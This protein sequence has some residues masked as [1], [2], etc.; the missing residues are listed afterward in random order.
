MFSVNVFYSNVSHPRC[1]P[2]AEKDQ[3]LVLYDKT[4]HFIKNGEMRDYQVRGLNW[5]VQLQHNGI[6]G[7]LADEMVLV[8]S[9]L[10]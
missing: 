4:P 10:V 5:L 2:F 9:S 1:A 6:N 8:S 7:I 3:Q